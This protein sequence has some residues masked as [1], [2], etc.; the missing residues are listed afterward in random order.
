M[1]VFCKQTRLNIY[2]NFECCF[3]VVVFLRKFIFKLYTSSMSNYDKLFVYIICQTLYK[4]C[5]W[6]KFLSA[7]RINILWIWWSRQFVK[8]LRN[9]FSN[10]N[11]CFFIFFKSL[12]EVT[13]KL[14]IWSRIR[15]FFKS[16]LLKCGYLF[17]LQSYCFRV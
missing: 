11:T 1:F 7:I 5:V 8:L 17:L 13:P 2:S 15:F 14:K 3:F 9:C 6:Y 10:K 4:Q 12:H 16:K